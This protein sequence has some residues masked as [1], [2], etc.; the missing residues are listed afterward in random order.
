MLQQACYTVKYSIHNGSPQ[1]AADLLHQGGLGVSHIT[2][3]Q[4]FVQLMLLL[5]TPLVQWG[6]NCALASRNYLLGIALFPT[7]AWPMFCW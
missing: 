3:C 4:Q 1:V 5:Y 6:T 7:G 2:T